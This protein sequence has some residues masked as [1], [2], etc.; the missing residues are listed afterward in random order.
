MKIEAAVL[1]HGR[2]EREFEAAGALAVCELELA[3]PGPGEVRIRVAAAGVCHSDL[4]VINGT[5]PRPVPMVL[6]HEASGYVEEV[7]AGVDDLAPGDHVVC[8]FAPGCGN[9][10]PCAEGRPALCTRA[11]KHIN[12]TDSA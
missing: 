9:C 11:A 1:L 6:G 7:G 10:L 12:T 5:R 2:V 8:I 3:A 4:S